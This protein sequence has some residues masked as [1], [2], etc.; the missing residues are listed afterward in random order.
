MKKYITIKNLGWTFIV[1]TS[2]MML[3]SGTSKIIGTEEMIKN[4]SQ[5][6]KQILKEILTKISKVKKF[7]GQ[8]FLVGPK[9]TA[10]I[11][12]MGLKKIGDILEGLKGMKFYLTGAKKYLQISF[13]YFDTDLKYLDYKTNLKKGQEEL[14]KSIEQIKTYLANP[15]LW[16]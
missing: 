3:F 5:Q 6:E 1:L 2:L 13:Q 14:T 4:L 11:K 7:S 15:D 9:N 16:K 8:F 10:E 12:K